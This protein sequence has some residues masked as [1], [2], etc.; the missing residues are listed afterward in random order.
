[1][2]IHIYVKKSFYT[3]SFVTFGYPNFDPRN[4]RHFSTF[5]SKLGHF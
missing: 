5:D 4:L 2:Y 3:D 1:M